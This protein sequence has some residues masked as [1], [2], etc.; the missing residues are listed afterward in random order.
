MA[1]TV[2]MRTQIS[3]LY[4][5]LFGRA[6]DAEGLGFWV[7]KLNAGTSLVDVANQMF[8]TAPAREYYP[9]AATNSEIIASFYL[10]VLG[11]TADA[12]GLAFWTA[13]LNAAGA[14]PGSVI[15]QMINNVANYTGTDPAG[16]TSAALFN[17]KVAVA[18]YYGEHAGD[19]ASADDILAGV[20]A[21]P[22]T[23]AAAKT[24][25]D[26]T[27][28]V[29][30]LTNGT[31]IAV[32]A[33]FNAGLV[34]TPGGDDRINSLQDEDKLTG[35]GTNATL[36]ATLGNAN[37]NGATIITPSLTNIANLNV[38]FTGSGGGAVTALDLQDA[39]G[40]KVANITRVS[41]A[42]N[43]AELGNIQSRLDR[44][45]VTNSNSNNAGI[46]EFSFGNGVLAGSSTGALAVNNVQVAALL[47]GQNTLGIVA[48]G[49]GVNGYE[50]LTLESNGSAA[51]VIGT[52]GLPMD[53][54]TDG[55]LTITGTANL[56]LGTRGNVVN[57]VNANL[58]EA[59]GV[60]TAATGVTQAGGRIATIDASGLKGNLNLVLDN[61]LDVGKADTSGVQQNVTVT[62][63]AGNDTFVLFD[64]IQAG[65]TLNGGDGTDLLQFYSGSSIA[66]TAAKF[67]SVNFFADGSTGN[68]GPIDFDFLPDVTASTVRNI[69]AAA[70]VNAAEAPITVTLLD[71]SAAQATG[72]SVLHATTGNNQIQNTIVEVAVKANTASDTIGV[73]IAEGTNTDPRFNFTVDTAV[74]NVSTSTTASAST[75][76]NVTITDSDTESNSV[77]LQNFTQ[78]TG[79][80]TLTGGLA[81]TFL[82]LDVDT[83]GADVAANG[84]ARAGTSLVLNPANGAT[85]VQQGLYQLNT[86]G[87]A[88]D[89][90]TGNIRDVGTLATQVR[91]GA[92]TINASG[93]LSNVIVRV[94]TNAADVNGAQSI[95][96]GKGDDT[97]IFDNLNDSRAGLTISD[98]VNAGEGND[99]LV[100]DGDGVIIQLG[101]SEWTNVSGFENLRLVGN[102]TPATGTGFPAFMGENSYNLVLTDAFI[103]ANKGSN[104][105][106]NIINDNDSNNDNAASAGSGAGEFTTNSSVES[107]VTID[108]RTLAATTHFSYNGEEGSWIDANA[109]GVYDVGVDTILPV[110]FGFG[111]FDRFIFGDANINGGNVI[112]GGANDNITTTW[113]NGL[114]GQNVGNWWNGGNW[115]VFEVRNGATVTTGDLANVKNI[116]I[117]AGTNDQAVA[118]TLVLQLND[119]VID[120]MVDSYHTST[121]TQQE[122]L[123]V[124]MNNAQ[125]I[126]APVAAAQLNLDT[127]QTTARSIVNVSLDTAF[128]SN[129]TAK[130]GMGQTWIAGYVAAND[131]IVLSRGQ[132]GLTAAIGNNYVATGG[133]IVY[134]ALGSG[135]TTDR[136]YIVETADVDASGTNDSQIY[137]DADGSGAGAA[138]LIGVVRDVALSATNGVDV[139]A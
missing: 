86:D 135:A 17:N 8:A 65:D 85:G 122:A 61:I 13:K 119:S 16:V 12:E 35:T 58:V 108:A 69:S 11:R 131:N 129:D 10:N 47:V 102:A 28:G 23:V 138:I 19:I 99:T 113:N 101:A 40:L 4:V 48:R 90:N 120:A 94:N 70:G 20:T 83:A 103:N 54:G 139:V 18:Q 57:A 95:T 21:D 43:T 106:L 34:Y 50:Q 27:V 123:W 52:L 41:Q 26:N 134:G 51:N 64:A 36:T 87:T 32:A 114:Y 80:I 89:M 137:F 66:N 46:V 117:V 38:A 42:V 104:G 39:S 81:G 76:E 74:A 33:S 62:G 132:Y 63:G 98:T 112:D 73:T 136:I 15:T 88:V 127:T 93:E 59:A 9:S 67:E 5:A 6:P 72:I 30:Q 130:L 49:V 115:D 2:Q 1:I 44:M 111:T 126:T 71:L 60:W 7:N 22:A 121:T 128:A 97:V 68:I 109:N 82:N 124:R 84:N 79:T 116:G 118:Q 55:K 105:L 25:V 107:G 78:H 29:F 24:V 110:Q 31:D 91:L 37:D 92:A 75:F 133:G 77:E 96:M 125:D 45:T 56:T 53:T 3:Q 14:T 100:I